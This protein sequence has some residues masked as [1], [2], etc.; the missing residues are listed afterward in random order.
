LEK[1]TTL[2]TPKGTIYVLD[3]LALSSYQNISEYWT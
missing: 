3:L 2:V 1:P